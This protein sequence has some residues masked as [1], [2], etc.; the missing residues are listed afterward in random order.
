MCIPFSLLGCVVVSLWSR[1]WNG[2]W[3]GLLSG[4]LWCL[5]PNI[6][7]HGHLITPDVAATTFGI[8]TVYTFVHW[9][10]GPTWTR[11]LLVGVALALALLSKGT[12]IVLVGVLWLQWLGLRMLGV[13]LPGLAFR[14]VGK[15]IAIVPIV[16]L[17]GLDAAG[18]HRH[19]G[20]HPPRVA[21]HQLRTQRHHNHEIHDCD[22]LHC[23]KYKNDYLFAPSQASSAF[24]Q[25]LLRHWFL[26]RLAILLS[27]P[28]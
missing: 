24:I 3:G 27:S 7:A 18:N 10:K 15:L 5:C 28:M 6:L 21:N 12:W 8:A 20:D 22:E 17:L 2:D 11:S 4:T 23:C 26:Q 13:R 25:V 14:E 16:G 1:E 9:L 19:R